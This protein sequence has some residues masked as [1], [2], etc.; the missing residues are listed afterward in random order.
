MSVLQSL[1]FLVNRVVQC[2]Y[3]SGTRSDLLDN[4]C[5][6]SFWFVCYYL[7]WS[8]L[9]SAGPILAG[10]SCVACAYIGLAL[11]PRMSYHVL[12]CL[13]VNSVLCCVRVY[14]VLCCP[15]VCP[16]FYC[17][18]V[19]SILSCIAP[20]YILSCIAPAYILSCLLLPPR[21]SCL[22][23]PP[24]LSCLV[25]PPRISCLVLP[26][27]TSCLVLPPRLVLSRRL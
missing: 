9:G 17:L 1:G 15:R 11:P 20:A 26:P 18:R 25:L 16:V 13:R 14:P 23:L 21:I 22:V 10:L 7:V 5:T 3:S 19:F 8:D 4:P 24:P 27:P 2:F 6:V 12:Y